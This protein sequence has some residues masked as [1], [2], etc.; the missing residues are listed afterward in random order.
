MAGRTG[1]REDERG[2]YREC[3]GSL[4]GRGRGRLRRRATGDPAVSA[5][6]ASASPRRCGSGRTDVGDPRRGRVFFQ[7][8]FGRNRNTE[9]SEEQTSTQVTNAHHVCML[10]L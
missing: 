1:R 7:G 6:G 3:R 4:G 10:L 5:D 8:Q 9:R 2:G